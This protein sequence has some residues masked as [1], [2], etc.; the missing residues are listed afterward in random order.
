[1]SQTA[2]LVGAIILVAIAL[3]LAIWSGIRSLSPQGREI[4]KL[5]GTFPTREAEM[6]ERMPS[7]APT[8]QGSQ[9]R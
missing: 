7:P 9:T 2:K 1:M 5:P 6:G 4:G 8:P 3:A